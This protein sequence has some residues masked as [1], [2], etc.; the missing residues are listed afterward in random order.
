MVVKRTLKW[1]CLGLAITACN[2]WADVTSEESGKLTQATSG[3]TIFAIQGSQNLNGSIKILSGS[4][5]EINLTYKKWARAGSESQAKQFLELIKL[6]LQPIENNKVTLSIDTPTQAPWQGSNYGVSLDIFIELPEKMKIE[7]DLHFMKLEVRGPFAAVTIKSEFSALSL[8]DIAGPIDIATTYAAINLAGITGTI[9]A[10]TRNGSIEASDIKVPMGSAIFQ[11]TIGTIKLSNISGPVEA[12]TTYSAI[13]ACDIN[14]A[15]GSVV[16]RTTYSPI[17]ASDV[18]G[19][20]VCE[21]SFSPINLDDVA[22]TH[23]Q[24]KIETSYSPIIANFKEISDCQLFINTTYS[25]IG[26]E[27]PPNTSSQ[28]VANV[29]EGGKIHASDL[30]IIPTFLG[31]TRLE[32]SL[33]DGQSRIELKVGGIGEINIESQ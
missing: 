33:N 8:E 7:G 2:V 28:I 18:S 24:S 25:N 27:L 10:E 11:N 19:E 14:A 29:D 17:N 30:P 12:Y 1:L 21:T 26:L 16:L 6:S 32:G 15:D 20:L 9:K 3:Q 5:N 4:E 23:G 13:N 22:L 31:A